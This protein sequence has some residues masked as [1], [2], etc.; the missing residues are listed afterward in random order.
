MQYG[1]CPRW[2]SARTCP[3]ALRRLDPE[4]CLAAHWWEALEAPPHCEAP[5]GVFCRSAAAGSGLCRSRGKSWA[6]PRSRGGAAERRKRRPGPQYG[7][8]PSSPSERG[9]EGLRA[10]GLT[11]G[12]ISAAGP[13][14]WRV[15]RPEGEGHSLMF[16]RTS[17]GRRGLFTLAPWSGAL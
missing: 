15:E 4:K 16:C 10:W 6:R 2:R 3:L 12:P 11:L 9:T 14:A 13:G 8:L 1:A 5:P 7:P 17:S